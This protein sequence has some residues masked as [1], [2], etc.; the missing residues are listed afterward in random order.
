MTAME[1]PRVIGHIVAVHGFRVKVE[2]LP[3]TRSPLRATL[4]GVQVVVAINSYIS[5]SIGAGQVVIGTITD[6]EARESYD[7]AAGDDLTLELLKPRRIASV[8][9]LGTVEEGVFNPGI[10]IL[11]T[12]DAP[13]VIGAPKVLKAVLE[14]PPRRNKPEYYEGEDFDCNLRIG[15]P[16]GQPTTAVQASYNDLFSRPLA[17]V[18]NTGSGKS[19][20]VS[21]LVQKA[22]ESLK[23]AREEPHVFVLDIN[24]E[25]GKAFPQETGN[26]ERRPDHV[27]L[28]GK[29][30]GIPIWLLNAEEICFWLSASEQTQEQVLK[31]WW[32]I[33]KGG[34]GT[35]GCW[36]QLPPAR[37]QFNRATDDRIGQS[38]AEKRRVLLRRDLWPPCWLR[39]RSGRV[40]RVV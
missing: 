11:P 7:P 32:A 36:S 3:D 30:F 15:S 29:E 35:R 31:D 12:L 2:L 17:I 9:L 27:Y 22:M 33:A 10:T 13:A 24:G 16:T 25:Y 5:F 18:G 37:S 34:T 1:N 23:G 4:D 26:K 6:L 8:Q 21:S 40:Q 20:T 28:N 14:S 19:F 38:E 39:Y